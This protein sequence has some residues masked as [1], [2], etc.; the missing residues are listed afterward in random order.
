MNKVILLLGAGGNAGINF[1]KC[2]KLK[3]KNTKIVG[4]DINKFNLISSNSDF[5]Y[6]LDKNI[7]NKEKINVINNLIKVHKV[8]FIHAQPDPEVE[9]LCKNKENINSEIFDHDFSLCKLMADK[10]KC[11]KIWQNKLGFKYTTCTLLEAIKD[12][13]LWDSVL[14]DNIAVW[15]RSIKGA[16]SKAAL[17]VRSI[18]QAEDWADYWKSR[19]LDKKDFMLSEYLPG[20]EYAVQTFWVKGKLI[21]AQA[22]Q[23][24]E[25]FFGNLMPSGQSSTPS[26]AKTIKNENVYNT[27]LKA[28]RSITEKPHG[29]FCVDLKENKNKIIIPME[30]NYGRFFTTSDFFGNLGINTPDVYINWKEIKE[31]DIKINSLND[32][33]YWLRGLDKEPTLISESE[34]KKEI[35]ICP[36]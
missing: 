8:D 25:Y 11:S 29:I 15:C 28:I 13:A 1:V 26:V 5:K 23:R 32:T 17:P 22:R 2:L 4:V 3:D 12:P 18:K 33:F 6:L 19:G 30:I 24:L 27:A 31:S 16:G 9:F 7:N 36:Q 35:N 21:H 10:L 20:N 34:I 14:N